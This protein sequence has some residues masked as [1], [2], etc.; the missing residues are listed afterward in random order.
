M[1]NAYQ[2]DPYGI[3]HVAKKVLEFKRKSRLDHKT[4]CWVWC[5]AK[6][7]RGYGH[8]SFKGRQWRALRLAVIF[9]GREIPVGMEV[10]HICRNHSCVNPAHLE[11]VTHTV[12]VRRGLAGEVNGG[13]NRAKTHCPYGHPYEGENLIITKRKNGRQQRKCRECARRASRASA[14]AKRMASQS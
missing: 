2:R 5:G 13:R 6:G 12:N 14:A 10:D 9:D 8:F 7:P 11:I 4:G 3:A 1:L